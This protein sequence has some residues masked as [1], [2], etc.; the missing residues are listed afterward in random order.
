VGVT[1]DPGERLDIRLERCPRCGEL[2]PARLEEGD[3]SPVFVRWSLRKSEACDHMIVDAFSVENW[4]SD[5]VD[6]APPDPVEERP[7]E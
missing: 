4:P 3:R 1:P 2:M 5:S 7:S 6:D